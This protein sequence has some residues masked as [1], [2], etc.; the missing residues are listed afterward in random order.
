[1]DEDKQAIGTFLGSEGGI[2]GSEGFSNAGSKG[3]FLLEY[4]LQLIFIFWFAALV[5]RHFRGPR[6]ARRELMKWLLSEQ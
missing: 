1:M 5:T 4:G 3:P 6:G 2:H